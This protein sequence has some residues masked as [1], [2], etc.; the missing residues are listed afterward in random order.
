M[1]VELT[2]TDGVG[3]YIVQCINGC[4]SIEHTDDEAIVCLGDEESVDQILD[5]LRD[6]RAKCK[7]ISVE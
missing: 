7:E 3:S 1:K 6:V 5:V 4:Y 2:V